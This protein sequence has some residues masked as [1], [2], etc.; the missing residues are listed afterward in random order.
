MS[1]FSDKSH[2]CGLSKDVAFPCGIA[3]QPG[4][5]T[6]YLTVKGSSPDTPFSKKVWTALGCQAVSC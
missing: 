5:K 1:L 4:G 2:D 3:E 6:F